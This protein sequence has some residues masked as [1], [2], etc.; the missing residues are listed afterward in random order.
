MPPH[1]PPAFAVA[2]APHTRPTA[3]PRPT[4]KSGRADPSSAI[5]R[6]N[7]DI[8]RAQALDLQHQALA[9]PRPPR[10]SAPPQPAFDLTQRLPRPVAPMRARWRPPRVIRDPLLRMCFNQRPTAP[11]AYPSP[12]SLC[13][14]VWTPPCPPARVSGQSPTRPPQP[15]PGSDHK[16]KRRRVRIHCAPRPRP[17]PPT[18]PNP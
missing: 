1:P 18:P 11:D 6:S 5:G 15:P 12:I 16:P 7:S 9:P 14:G 13:S 8:I 3:P 10:P 2:P 17:S 4:P